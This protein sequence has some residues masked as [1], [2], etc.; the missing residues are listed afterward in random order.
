MSSKILISPWAAHSRR[1][2]SLGGYTN[3]SGR[4]IIYIGYISGMVF[5]AI[6]C[7]GWNNL[8][9]GHIIWRAASL[10]ILCIPVYFLLVI[11]YCRVFPNIYFEYFIDTTIT[12]SVA[13]Y[14][15]ARIGL[16]VLMLLSLR[17]LP[18]GAYDTVAWTKFIPHTNL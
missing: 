9:Q 10:A 7:T 18:P 2:P 14:I 3:T 4:T 17:S 13:T 6:H 16:I 1:V 8:F 12:I 11:S 5:G 15:V